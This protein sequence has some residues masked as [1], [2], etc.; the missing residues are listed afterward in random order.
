MWINSE[1]FTTFSY[2]LFPDTQSGKMKI[3]WEAGDSN[4]SAVTCVQI[5]IAD[6]GN[7]IVKLTDLWEHYCRV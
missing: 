1:I 3:D 5:K 7:K 4:I 6:A 2:F